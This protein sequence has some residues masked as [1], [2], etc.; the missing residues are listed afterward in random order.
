V[1]N[2]LLLIFLLAAPF[3][4][5]EEATNLLSK[6]EPVPPFPEV[7][8]EAKKDGIPLDGIN[9][10]ASTNALAPGDSI[11]A[12]ITLHQKGNRRTQW[13]VYF[14]II[15]PTNQPDAKPDKPTVLYNS[16]GHKFEFAS[17]PAIFS[18]RALGPYVDTVSIWGQPVSKDKYA[19]ASVDGN[20]LG[21][22]M[23]KAA[24]A[25]HRINLAEKETHATNFEFWV[26]DAPPKPPR[27]QRNQKLAAALH[28]TPQ[29]ERALAGWYPALESYFDAVGETPNLETIMWKVV[30]L[31]S[32][33]SIVRHAGVT[34]WIGVNPD[35][36]GPISLPRHWDLPTPAPVYTLPI[37]VTLNQ[38]DALNATLLI[39]DPHPPLLACGG[40]IG[41]LA[42]NPDDKEDYM[43][44]RVISAH[45]G[46][47][48]PEKEKAAIN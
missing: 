39:T 25:V 26:E 15:P 9:P 24:A 47:N 21:L 14:Q 22:G 31:P 2:L 48:P 11:T 7:Q 16:L 20:F 44:L 32:M 6:L 42:E 10:S 36:I 29:E 28:I 30:S 46:A 23:D 19:Q 1:K 43:T 45:C 40:I 17:A 35:A 34:A 4:N 5:A 37:A 3:C 13:L 18:I 33:W 27:A 12:L 8:Q 38:H 41:F